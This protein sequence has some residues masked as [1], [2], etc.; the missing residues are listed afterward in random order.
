MQ[1]DHII[2]LKTYADGVAMELELPLHDENE[3]SEIF[4]EPFSSSKCHVCSK[5][6]CP[7]LFF[8]NSH[9]DNNPVAICKECCFQLF[10]I[11]ENVPTKMK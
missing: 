4:G 1:S 2:K 9:G 10:S 5:S 3:H 11:L 8:E 7:H 6:N